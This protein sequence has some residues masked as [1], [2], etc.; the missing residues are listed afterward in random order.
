MKPANGRY[1]QSAINEAGWPEKKD[2]CVEEV[3][4]GPRG[5]TANQCSRKR[6]H[7][8]NGEYCKQHAKRAEERTQ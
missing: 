8:P 3:W 1:N 6:G 5:M 2:Q 7:G 4:N